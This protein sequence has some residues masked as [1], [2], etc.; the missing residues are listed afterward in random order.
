M[1]RK[2]THL[3]ESSLQLELKE[4]FWNKGP[5]YGEGKKK[6]RKTDIGKGGNMTFISPRLQG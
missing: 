4:A 5:S 2:S 3:R 1:N 6:E